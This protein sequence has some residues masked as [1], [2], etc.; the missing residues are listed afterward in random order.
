MAKKRIR[1]QLDDDEEGRPQP[2]DEVMEGETFAEYWTRQNKEDDI[3]EREARLTA[4]QW[5]DLE[6]TDPNMGAL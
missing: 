3:A 6:R 1:K 2:T 4:K 5:D